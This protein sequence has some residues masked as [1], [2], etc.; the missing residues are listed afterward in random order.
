M[1][2]SSSL[3]K[4]KESNVLLL[5]MSCDYTVLIFK[6]ATM[7]PLPGSLFSSRAQHRSQMPF[8]SASKQPRAAGTTVRLGGGFTQGLTEQLKDELEARKATP[9]L[10]TLISHYISLDGKPLDKV[11]Y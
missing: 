10:E 11:K 8:S 1:M 2:H 9:D 7:R 5:V 3:L 4:K 6:H